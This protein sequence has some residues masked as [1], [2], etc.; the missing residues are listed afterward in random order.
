MLGSPDSVYIIY[1]KLR[2]VFTSI[3]SWVLFGLDE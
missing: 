1:F 3:N 2:N